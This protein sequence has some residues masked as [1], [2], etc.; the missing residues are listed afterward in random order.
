MG[1]QTST[2][3]QLSIPIYGFAHAHNENAYLAE[4]EQGAEVTTL[5]SQFWGINTKYHR[6]QTKYNL[7]Q[8]FRYI[9]NKA[10][11][12]NDAI[13]EELTSSNFKIKYHFLSNLDASYVGMAKNISRKFN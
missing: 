13:G 12:G 2:I 8:I 9:I 10:G 7:R 1:Y 6:I 5:Y 11:D 4:I 3:P